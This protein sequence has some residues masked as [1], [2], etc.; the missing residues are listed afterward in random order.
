MNFLFTKN[1]IASLVFFRIAFGILAFLDVLVTWIYYHLKMN[2]FDPANY[3]FKYIGFEWAQAIPEPF[4]SLFFICLCMA[5]LGIALGYYYKACCIFFAFGFTYVFLLEKANYLNH[6][7][8]F[9]LISYM[10]IFFP[11][12]RAFSFDSLK[13]RVK[14][15]EYIPYWPI[16]VLQF[17]MAVVYIY[18]GIA[19]LN[20]DWLHAYPLKIWLPYKKDYFLIGNLLNQEWLAWFMSYGGLF[21]DLFIIPFMIVKRTR[22]LAFGGAIVFHLMNTAIFQIGIFPWLSLVLTALFFGSEFPLSLNNYLKNKVPM[23]RRWNLSYLKVLSKNKL[24]LN[25]ANY[26]ESKNQNLIKIALSIYFLYMLIVPFRHH[27]YKGNVAWTEEG[28][29]YSWRMML[30]GK[31]AYGHYLVKNNITKEEIKVKPKEI[32]SKKQARKSLTHP[33]MIW[34]FGNHL[35]DIYKDKWQTDSVSVYPNVKAKLHFRKYQEFVEPNTDL[36]K[37][38][39]KHLESADWI[40]PLKEK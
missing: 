13:G 30:R 20:S 6:A 15:I 39:W 3:Q 35:G 37:K 29:R 21:H 17:S 12:D 11:A 34:Q 10:M 23:V 7:Y 27:L 1:H 25:K 40:V 2:A 22:W 31:R 14:Y 18:G 26:K 16:F 5:A 33:D 28:H 4:M 9:C 19:K 24:H 36:T 38:E 8:L 32:L